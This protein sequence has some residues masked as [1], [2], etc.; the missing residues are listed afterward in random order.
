MTDAALSSTAGA[1]ASRAPIAAFVA[2]VTLSA[3]LLFGVQPMFAKM[4]LPSLGGAPAVWSVA[5]V[6]FQS[7]LLCGYAYAH[8]LTSRLPIRVAAVVHIVVLLTAFASLPIVVSSG[9]GRPQE[10]GEAVWLVGVFF[11]SIGLP[12]F[13]LS[14]NGPL[15]QAWFATSG[16]RGAENPYFLYAASNLG[17]FGALLAYPF[18]IE[19]FITLKQQSGFW[20]M[21]FAALIVLIATAGWLARDGVRKTEQET[22]AA[23]PDHRLTWI[24][25]AFVPS[26][27]LVAVTAHISTDVAA[28]PMLW[29]APLALFLL[30]FVVAFRETPLVSPA[31]LAQAQVWLTAAVLVGFVA[32]LPI[33]VTLPLH[34]TL[35][36]VTAVAAHGALFRLRPATGDLT[37]FYL[38]MSLGGVLGGS[39]CSLAAP[40]L[41]PIVLEYPILLTAALACLPAISSKELRRTLPRS[42]LALATALGLFALAL[43][44]SVPSSRFVIFLAM[45]ALAGLLALSWRRRA[46]ALCF[47]AT[48]AALAA[49]LAW[50]SGGVETV[51]SFFGV[52]KIAETADGRFLTLVHGTTVHGAAR[53]RNDDGSPFTDRA[54]PTAY[55]HPEGAMGRAISAIREARDGALPSVAIVGLGAGS[56]SC[57]AAQG[58]D[59]RFYEIDAE[60]VRIARPGG[61]FP[62]LRDCA[63]NVS[64]TLGDARLTLA[65][66]APAAL[67]VIDA[68]SS[69]AI[70]LH[71][72]TREAVAL[73]LSKLDHRGSVILHISNRHLELSHILARVGAEFGLTAFL[74]REGPE[75]GAPR[76]MKFRSTALVLTRSPADVGVLA[77]N[78]EWTTVVPDMSRRPWSDDF[79]NVIEAIVDNQRL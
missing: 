6:V 66:A 72:L 15:L 44:S 8:L 61:P 20:S 70:P 16:R 33:W 7:L 32:P 4:V 36:F 34:L 45:L 47:G 74:R 76:E 60:V 54:Q 49:L 59:W 12:F 78:G 48:A 17:S 22:A 14:A 24:G 58:E 26:G 10:S 35:F 77:A 52:H 37:R 23:G 79:S 5:M 63:P 2:A 38:Y 51:R 28:M 21:G 18:L 19:P 9:L 13:A 25:L 40:L 11:A 43:W 50:P 68:F 57:H 73:Y 29:I 75:E 42:D 67:L 30:S 46:S 39:F 53:I 27:L 56:L 3:F 65:D 41:F 1:S 64:I 31:R 69:D 71:L 62:F 55:Y